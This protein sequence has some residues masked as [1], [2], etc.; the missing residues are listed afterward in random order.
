MPDASIDQMIPARRPMQTPLQEEAHAI[1]EAA[2]MLFAER[3][4]NAISL[5]DIATEAEL[6]LGQVRQH[7]N[8]KFAILSGFGQM[9]DDRVLAETDADSLEEPLRDR[10]FDLLIRRFEE[11]TPFRPGIKA[12]MS[13]AR[14]NPLIALHLG[15]RLAVSMATVLEASGVSATA[16]L[17]L[18]RVSALSA[19]WLNSARVWIDDDSRDLS[20]T[21]ASL[22][23]GLDQLH[24]LASSLPAPLRGH[25]G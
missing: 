5:S 20:A 15:P 4:Y 9:V 1:V 13:A 10:L 24:S 8:D 17:G 14:R 12:V 3:G 19:L 16:P 7:Y 22:D 6:S 2:F 23:R 21:M 18:P 25:D 11:M